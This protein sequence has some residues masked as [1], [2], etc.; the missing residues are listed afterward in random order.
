MEVWTLVVARPHLSPSPGPGWPNEAAERGGCDAACEGRQAISVRVR[1][2]N[3][4]LGSGGN[5]LLGHVF[6]K[7]GTAVNVSGVDEDASAQSSSTDEDL[8]DYLFLYLFLGWQNVP[9]NWTWSGLKPP[10]SWE[11]RQGWI[12]RRPALSG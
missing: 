8:K 12:G 4:G 6:G 5:N 2:A 1:R 7:D 10:P 11:Q 3:L 9:A